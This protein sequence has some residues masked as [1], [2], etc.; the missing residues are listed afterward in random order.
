MMIMGSDAIVERSL[1][2]LYDNTLLTAGEKMRLSKGY[3][4]KLSIKDPNDF[5]NILSTI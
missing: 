1:I 2:H 4:S 3:A 5:A